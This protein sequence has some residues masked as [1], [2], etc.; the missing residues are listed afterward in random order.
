MPSSRRWTSAA[1]VSQTTASSVQQRLKERLMTSAP[2]HWF[3]RRSINDS[4]THSGGG[5]QCMSSQQLAHNHISCPQS[6]I[7]PTVTQ[8]AH[9]YTMGTLT[10]L[11]HS[12]SACL[13]SLNLPTLIQLAHSHTMPTL[14]QPAHTFTICPQSHSLPTI[15][16][17]PH[18]ACPQSHNLPTVTYL[19]H[20]HTTCPVT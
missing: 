7:L 11:A 17:C 19:A 4:L 1:E 8:L 5:G 15:T 14:T 12:H 20:S 13:Q 3:T 18:L 16:Q 6:H 9:S 10:Q 2:G